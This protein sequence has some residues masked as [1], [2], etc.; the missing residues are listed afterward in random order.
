MA[1]QYLCVSKPDASSL[2]SICMD[3]AYK[4][5]QCEDLRRMGGSLAKLV[6][7]TIPDTSK[8]LEVSLTIIRSELLNASGLGL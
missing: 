4:P 8:I 2:C 3:L 7:L 5:K 6:G 1:S